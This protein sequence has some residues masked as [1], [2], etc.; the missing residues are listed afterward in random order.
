MHFMQK[1][2][3]NLGT[4][5]KSSCYW[6]HPHSY[7]FVH[8]HQNVCNLTFSTQDGEGKIGNQKTMINFIVCILLCIIT[9]HLNLVLHLH[10][11]G[12]YN[13]QGMS[14]H[15]NLWTWTLT[16]MWLQTFHL[17]SITKPSWEYSWCKTEIRHISCYCN[18]EESL[19]CK[20]ICS[21]SFT[22]KKCVKY[23]FVISFNP[24]ICPWNHFVIWWIHL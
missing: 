22:P 1:V 24:T 12:K 16:K 3:N 4:K 8:Q 14:K 9:K 19:L 18:K 6:N 5:I 7:H 17:F 10:D 15:P 2:H 23:N 21:V 13:T 20:H 11:S